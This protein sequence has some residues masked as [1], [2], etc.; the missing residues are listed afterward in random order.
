MTTGTVFNAAALASAFH[1]A[2]VLTRKHSRTFYFATRLLPPAKRSAIRAL[3][4]FCRSTDDLVDLQHASPADVAAWRAQVTLPAARQPDARLSA[5]AHV[6]EQYGVNPRYEHELID[7]VALDLTNRR[8]QTWEE[9]EHY[10]YL[11]ASTVGLLSLPVIGLARGVQEGQAAPYAIRLGIALQLTNIL[12]DVGEDAARGHIYIPQADLHAFN[13][14][15]QDIFDG[16][17]DTRFVALMQ[18]E[19]ARAREIYRAALPG[20]AL[21]AP[22]ARAAVGAAA[23]LYAAILER[24]EAID[25]RVHSQRART[26]D[27]EKLLRLPGIFAYVQRLRHPDTATRLRPPIKF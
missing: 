18:F 26:T 20:I 5:W 12:R 25:Y 15:S 17:H 8:Y 13:L 11:V 27:L 23:L 1:A 10:C 7:G 22:A 14:T 3:Y 19:I 6:R 21:L 2:N 9:L 4:V 16:V 24:I